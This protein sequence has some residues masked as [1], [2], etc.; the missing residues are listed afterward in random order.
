MFDYSNLGYGVL[1]EVVAETS[2]T[3]LDAALRKLVFAP[4]GMSS[5]GVGPDL[6]QKKGQA[7]RYAI[8]P[9]RTKT[10]VVFSTTP[11]ASGV[12]CSVHD[13]AL[14]GIFHL[15][16][17]LASQKRVLSDAAIGEMQAPSLDPKVQ[18]QY[19]LSW[20]VQN[21]LHGYHGVQ[22]QGGTNDAIAWLQLIPS[23][24]IAVAVL[25]NTFVDG[26]KIVDDVLAAMLP[27]YAKNLAAAANVAAPPQA[28]PQPPAGPGEMA[29]HW[30]GFIQSYM[31]KVPLT[32]T[33]DATGSLAAKVAE[34]AEPVERARYGNKVVRWSMPASLGVEGEPFALAMK[35]FLRD[36]LLVGDGETTSAG[37]NPHGFQ[38]YYWVE[39]K[40]DR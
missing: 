39:L 11:G 13:L 25:A 30:S 35:L 24:D 4:L 37:P 27:E 33:I 31:G 28:A 23:E 38:T 3:S 14:F 12:Y 21:D 20:W 9:P 18:Q 34:Q 6:T 32:V 5:C 22:A 26:A 1:G 36:G 7:S 8:E 29:G 17:H 2:G 15:K 40:A 16:D 19:G 10:P